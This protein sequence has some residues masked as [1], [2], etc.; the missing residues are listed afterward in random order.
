MVTVL[1]LIGPLLAFVLLMGGLAL[2]YS[3]K[4]AQSFPN[5]LEKTCP[6]EGAWVP[7][8]IVDSTLTSQ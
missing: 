5:K 8:F 4:P 3:P 7:C 2:S 6:F 1:R